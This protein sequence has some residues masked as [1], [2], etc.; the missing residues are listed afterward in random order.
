VTQHWVHLAAHPHCCSFR[1][2]RFTLPPTAT[3][4]P[5]LPLPLLYRLPSHTAFCKALAPKLTDTGTRS[6]CVTVR[7]P[8][9][10][11]LSVSVTSCLHT[12]RSHV[13]RPSVSVSLNPVLAFPE[14]KSQVPAFSI[15]TRHGLPYVCTKYLRRPY[16]TQ[17][18]VPRLFTPRSRVCV[19]TFHIPT[20]PVPTCYIPEF[21]AP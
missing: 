19:P 21:P 3:P 9:H 8:R 14:S 2:A 13:Q 1:L 7:V 12:S 4:S 16:T 6:H 15:S 10:K 18:A 17:I 20:F 5:S 11:Q